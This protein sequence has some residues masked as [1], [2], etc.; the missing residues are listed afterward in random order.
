MVEETGS[1]AGAAPTAGTGS[2]V[3]TLPVRFLMVTLARP[4]RFDIYTSCFSE[5]IDPVLCDSHFTVMQDEGCVDAGK[6]G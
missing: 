2:T 5:G 4:E 6:L 3:P 1:P